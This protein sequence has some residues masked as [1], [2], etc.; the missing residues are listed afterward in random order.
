MNL[1]KTY[2]WYT[3][4]L[5]LSLSKKLVSKITVFVYEAYEA[6]RRTTFPRN[7]GSSERLNACGS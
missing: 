4:Q 5:I 1:E 7:E 2:V 6:V 3:V